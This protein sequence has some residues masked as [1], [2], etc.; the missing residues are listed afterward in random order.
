MR[1]LSGS[2]C[3]LCAHAPA[4]FARRG[5]RGI[6]PEQAA[7]SPRKGVAIEQTKRRLRTRAKGAVSQV[8]REN[9]A[10]K[11]ITYKQKSHGTA[12]RLGATHDI[13]PFS[14]LRYTLCVR[15]I[16]DAICPAGASGIYIISQPT[17]G[18]G[19]IA[20]ERKLKYIAFAQAN[21]SPINKN[22][23]DIPWDFFFQTLT[24]RIQQLSIRG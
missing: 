17:A 3:A 14:D 23:T 19:Y 6:S 11:H 5:A 20:F 8:P 4:G 24:L 13:N 9:S 1:A 18:E 21:I 7:A 15:Y 12:L 10:N 16:F 2:P 22:P